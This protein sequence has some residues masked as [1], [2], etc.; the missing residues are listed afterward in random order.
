MIPNSTKLRIAAVIAVAGVAC[1]AGATETPTR[2]HSLETTKNIKD[3]L[4]SADALARD[5]GRD[6]LGHYLKLTFNKLDK[7]GLQVPSDIDISVETGHF[8]YCIT[9]TSKKLPE[10]HQWAVATAGLHT[11][12][13]QPQD[14]CPRR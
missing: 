13:V 6:H 7:A 14:R 2:D 11:D 4:G 1:G 12:G 9:A 3:T 8:G 10:M 5:Y